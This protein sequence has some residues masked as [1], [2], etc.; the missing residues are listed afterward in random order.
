MPIDVIDAT[1]T[2]APGPTP[3]LST[4][5]PSAAAAKPPAD[6]LEPTSTAAKAATALTGPPLSAADIAAL[7]ARGD[8]LVGVRD[9]VSAR[10]FY[11]RAVEA[12]DGRAALRM[13]AT[14]DPAFLDRANIRGVSGNQQETLSWYRRARALGEAKAE[15][16][17]KALQTQ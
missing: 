12:G 1:V 15:G 8:A 5:T 16:L 3:P 13:G 14:F 11:Q 10:L 7:V 9:I 4:S 6:I 17:L 2:L